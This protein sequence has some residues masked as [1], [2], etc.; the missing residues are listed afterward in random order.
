MT[1]QG[2][3]LFA[4]NPNNLFTLVKSLTTYKLS[5]ENIGLE[6]LAEVLNHT[7]I[8]VALTR[9]LSEH[10]L[11]INNFGRKLFQ[12][13]DSESTSPLKI[14][15]NIDEAKIV[16]IELWMS[17]NGFYSTKQKFISK[18]GEIFWGHAR[19]DYFF[20]GGQKYFLC[21]IENI[22]EEVKFS[23]EKIRHENRLQVL[24]DNA[25]I[26]I[27]VVNESG[28][29][30]FVNS[31]AERQFGYDKN[32]LINKTIEILIPINL[33]H[34]HKAHR[35][36]FMQKPQSR[37]MGI[38]M[39]L[40]GLKKD[41]S[42]F[43]VEISLSRF[44]TDEGKSVVAFIND[45][46]LRKKQEQ[47]LLLQ[48]NEL[49]LS[50]KAIRDLNT[51]LERKVEER[52]L[53]LRETL[54]QLER[55]K[56][57]VMQALEREKELGDLKSR[58]VSMASHEFR[59]PLATVLSSAS[60]I[61]KYEKLEE[62]EKRLKHVYRI[63][64]NVRNLTD[65]LEDF[66]SLGKLEEGLIESKRE[67]FSLPEFIKG[68]S[69]D[70]K[71]ASHPTQKLVLKHT[72]NLNVISDKHL[73]KNILINLLTNAI[74]FSAEQGSISIETDA[75]EKNI[76]IKVS[77]NGIGISLEDQQHLFDRFFRG[78]N[79]QNIKGTGLGLHIV[80]KYVELLQGKIS[81]E[82]K[83]NMGTTFAIHFPNF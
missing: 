80:S 82:S 10:F 30:S 31:F 25:T 1:R 34:D 66:L 79:A 47:D 71:E 55:S 39:D 57:E 42:Q 83:L 81:F 52:T 11:F 12:L 24:F 51:Q 40:F 6:T 59:T 37:P 23:Q 77:D 75:D 54:A 26:G 4:A 38:G 67:S 18:N 33:G 21:S 22:D 48:K 53:V 43:P 44:D 78:R 15:E 13:N 29:I 3:T 70:L 64:E 58:F 49:E 14:C 50:S 19:I 28:S 9:S 17:E 73:L 65:I 7:P 35:E 27:L 62:N 56:E 8:F 5:K 20:K 32:E 46:T 68:I 76:T 2:K 72:G 60:L 74:K 41:G 45:I 61:G 36:S 69:D 63:Q 16:E